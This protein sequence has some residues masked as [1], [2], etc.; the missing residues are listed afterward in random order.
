MILEL[1]ASGGRAAALTPLD[2]QPNGEPAM[3]DPA[4]AVLALI[5]QS[6]AER[7]H[8]AAEDVTRANELIEQARHEIQDA[9]KRAAE[10][11]EH[12]GLWSKLS[13]VFTG[14]V[15]AICELVA[16]AA[17]VAATGGTGAAGVLAI[18]AAGLCAGADVAEHLDLPPG[19]SIALSAGG[20]L[21]GLVA[22]NV[23]GSPGFWE[24]LAK[25]ANVTHT[26]ANAAG[27]GAQITA[28]KDRAAALDARTDATV[29][30]GRQ[31]DAVFDFNLAL[32]VLDRAARDTSRARATT[33]EIVKSDND[34]RSAL[35]ARLG[36]V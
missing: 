35:I 29:A 8:A 31:N 14:D 22:G 16:A 7:S 18:A 27:A 4:L 3:S 25:T 32:D 21:A 30:R 33:S 24:A 6:R 23:T 19:V 36:A 20:A 10:A 2:S 15:G 26:V 9:M 34:G 28:A 12:S 1:S 17:L 13:S 11:D 5:L